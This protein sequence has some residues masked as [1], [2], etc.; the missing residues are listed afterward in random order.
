MDG[1]RGGVGGE[2]QLVNRAERREDRKNIGSNRGQNFSN[3][4][5]TDQSQGNPSEENYVKL[6]HNLT[7]TTRNQGSAQKNEEH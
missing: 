7:D 3:L 2:G 1:R 6:H 5:T 4:M